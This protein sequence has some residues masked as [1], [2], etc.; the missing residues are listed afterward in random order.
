MTNRLGITC[1]KCDSTRT[2]VVQTQRGNHHVE[3]IRICKNCKHRMGTIEI[4]S[5]HLT[6]DPKFDFL[7][8]TSA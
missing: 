4:N 3:R 2:F 6:T 7:F 5:T 1:G 8:R